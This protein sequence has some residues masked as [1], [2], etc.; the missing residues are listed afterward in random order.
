M[1]LSEIDITRLFSVGS[2][3]SLMVW[4]D[5]P[6]WPVSYTSPNVVEL[7]GY[8]K[9]D[10]ES[11]RVDYKQLVHPD[12]YDRIRAEA[13]DAVADLTRESVNH[14]DY[15][16]R[17]ADGHWVWVSDTTLIDRY[18]DGSRRN[19][20][21]YLIDITERK[22]LELALELERNRLKLLLDATRLGTWEWNP[23]SGQVL[24]NERWAQM[25]GY[26]TAELDDHVDSW[27]SRLH[28]DDYDRV[29]ELVRAH[30][31]GETPFYESMHRL[32]HRDGH[33][34]YVLDRGKVIERDSSGK[35]TRF[36]GTLTD[37]SAQK[38]SE[39]EARR[40]AHAKSVF[41]ANMSHEIRTPLHGILGIASVLKDTDLDANQRNLVATIK[42]SGGYL[43][44]TLND[45]LD[46]T[47]AEEGQLRIHRGRSDVVAIFDHL[48]T[49]FA[50]TAVTKGIKLSIRVNTEVPKIL[51]LDKARVLQVLSNLINN[52]IKFTE[53]GEVE[54]V[55]GWQKDNNHKK[56]ELVVTVKDSGVGIEDT[57]RIWQLF[58]QERSGIDQ[59][60]SGTGLGLAIVRHLVQLM[61]GTVRV[62][63]RLGEGSTFTVTLPSSAME[64][65]EL[66]D[67]TF[68]GLERLP[69]M[70][71]LVVDDNSVNRLIISEM[72]K[73]LQQQ[74][75]LANNATEALELLQQRPFDVVFMDI[76]MPELDGLQATKMIRDMP[77]KQPY[78]VAL[79]ANA[80]VE[81][82][83]QAL[84]AGMDNYVTKPF[85]REDIARILNQA[86]NALDVN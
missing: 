23:Q 76:H 72:L 35:A 82:K 33:Y 49:L 45:V 86:A 79:T 73:T 85:V 69:P 60:Q 27:S 40:A 64:E 6:N 4:A 30:R 52:A 36:A 66:A 62:D 24:F 34:L 14:S 77:L 43:L 2:K 84:R 28:P 80:F 47:R 26:S 21:G 54:V 19:M 68:V 81:T 1:K 65:N 41:L 5:G 38:H 74:C 63:S 51:L 8:S 46:L 3:M 18:E 29:W 39:M 67:P 75:E 57:R 13:A 42:E 53:N 11:Q 44:N 78:I 20:F 61:N 9:E 71:C 37:I 22:S 31:D 25:F 56:G 50:Q 17:H 70:R 7:I 55:A 59:A 58:E 32:R 15:R 83:T 12:D 10:F 48:Q 16:I